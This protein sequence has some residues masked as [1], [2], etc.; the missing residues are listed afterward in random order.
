MDTPR[1]LT[2]FAAIF[3]SGTL[4]SRVLGLVRDM[5]MAAFIPAAAR[6]TFL[7]AFSLPN[8]LRDMLGEGAT[9]AVF[10]P[11][12]TEAREKRGEEEYRRTIRALLGAMTLL[13]AALTLL[14][15]LLMPLVPAALELVRPLTRGAAIPPEQLA[16]TVQVLQWTFPYLFLIGVAVF[17]MAPLFIARHYLTP[18][19]A[20]A[21]LSIPTILL[22]V[23][24]HDAFA[25]PVWA[26]VVSVWI[27][28]ILQLVA[29][30]LAMRRYTGIWRPSFHLAHPGVARAALLLGPVILGQAAGEINKLVDRFFAFSFGESTVSAL[31]FANRLVQ[32]PL[33][34]FGI[35]VSV[36]ILP[37]ISRAGAQD[38]ADGIRH[39][40]RLGF[41]QTY[42][43]N[44]PAMAG[45]LVLAQPI[46]ELLF[47]RGAFTQADADRTAL[48][49]TY[50]GAG[51]VFFAFIKIAVQGF[52]AVQDTRTPVI[53]ASACM[54]LNM[55][56]LIAL[57][58]VMGWSGL[59]LATTIAY[60]LN[61]VGLHIA[62][63]R[64]Y[65]AVFDGAA[66]RAIGKITL[67]TLA[68]AA[69]TI[70]VMQLCQ[71][72]AGDASLAARLI[73][74]VIPISIAVPAFVVFCLLLRV[75]E[76]RNV[77]NL[78]LRR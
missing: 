25:H 65:G 58:R 15:V 28:G 42:L 48:A 16:L 23:F 3:A 31:F 38:H 24:M 11:V 47:L 14:G 4:F 53:I 46:V 8:M 55:V 9:N 5:A 45:L 43:L 49:A 10:V 64:R 36:A 37:S 60:G 57:S 66:L 44:A 59:P 21:L 13:F 34:I 72:Y 56:L 30:L 12:L 33:A 54:I 75:E 7:F 27:G 35:A 68:M 19:W 40:L 63:R 70:G 78:L 73:N 76:L 52:Y 18:S 41:R 51:L 67:A 61:Y 39:Y 69:L 1:N 71:H 62:L 77:L 26:L 22:C 29:M 6:D 50:Y 74:V 2:R 20:P 17:A 32:L